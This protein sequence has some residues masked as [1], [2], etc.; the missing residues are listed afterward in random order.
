[1]PEA[2]LNFETYAQTLQQV[3]ADAIAKAEA[4]KAEA[5]A[6]RNAAIADNQKTQDILR[7][8]E[9]EAHRAAEND[10]PALRNR[11]EQEFQALIEE[12]LSNSGKPKEEIAALIR[13]LA[14]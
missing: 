6:D 14:G 9:T 5:E 11:I 2:P 8:L 1:M 13:I 12:K 3:M 10:V 7:G 4:L